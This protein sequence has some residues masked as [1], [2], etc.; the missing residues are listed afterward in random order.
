MGNPGDGSG[1]L[2]FWRAFSTHLDPSAIKP[3]PVRLQRALCVDSRKDDVYHGR[4]GRHSLCVHRRRIQG[5]WMEGN[6]RLG[7]AGNGE[8]SATVPGW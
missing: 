2:L 1:P 7:D 6:S 3:V 8:P 5:P 4:V